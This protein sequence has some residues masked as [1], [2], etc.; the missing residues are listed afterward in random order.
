MRYETTYKIARNGNY[1]YTCDNGQ[2]VW[3][4]TLWEVDHAGKRHYIE[5]RFTDGAYCE[6]R[7]VSVGKWTKTVISDNKEL[8]EYLERL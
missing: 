1:Y 3:C 8:I 4:E 5:A 7:D 6:A 2:I